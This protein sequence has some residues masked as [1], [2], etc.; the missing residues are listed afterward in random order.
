MGANDGSEVE[1][2]RGRKGRPSTEAVLDSTQRRSGVKVEEQAVGEGEAGERRKSTRGSGA[3]EG[4]GLECTG[5]ASDIE[6][7]SRRRSKSTGQGEADAV[8]EDVR[9]SKAERKGRTS[10]S[11]EGHVLESKVE[12]KE[13]KDAKEATE[14]KESKETKEV[15]ETKEAKETKEDS[16]IAKRKSENGDVQMEKCEGSDDTVPAQKDMEDVKEEDKVEDEDKEVKTKEEREDKGEEKQ[17]QKGKRGKKKEEKELR[18][19]RE[20]NGSEAFEVAK[21]VAE[22]DKGWAIDVVG[23]GFGKASN[24]P[25]KESMEEM[26]TEKRDTLENS[27][28][29]E[30]MKEADTGCDNS[31]DKNSGE[32]ESEETVQDCEDVNDEG[33]ND[34]AEQTVSK[35]EG[36]EK[37]SVSKDKDKDKDKEHACE[38]KEVKEKK[39]SSKGSSELAALQQDVS[40]SDMLMSSMVDTGKRRCTPATYFTYDDTGNQT[41][42]KDLPKGSHLPNKSP[43]K[44][45]GHRGKTRE[46][47]GLGVEPTRAGRRAALEAF[48]EPPRRERQQPER[49]D[50]MQA[51]RV[52]KAK[53]TPPS[54]A[55]AAGSTRRTMNGRRDSEGGDDD[56]STANGNTGHDDKEGK[57]GA[58]RADSHA[59]GNE[60]GLIGRGKDGKKGTPQKEEGDDALLDDNANQTRAVR[61]TRKRGAK[62]EEEVIE[63]EIDEENGGL[64][65]K[66]GRAIKK[67]KAA[68]DEVE[69]EEA[70]NTGSTAGGEEGEEEDESISTRRIVIHG[71]HKEDHAQHVSKDSELDSSR[72]RKQTAD[73]D[74]EGDEV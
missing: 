4:G 67:D 52:K 23:K 32:H 70:L 30:E 63:A 47:T 29:N 46:L 22:N 59:D 73:E 48:E 66:K 7:G 12:V 18:S 20:A 34:D 35:D 2:K 39:R 24:E 43:D 61:S 28:M 27:D 72:K 5:V 45:E 8:K 49:Y 69:V 33:A 40:K 60:N 41:T 14:P 74:G 64:A 15:K 51:P 38:K 62:H 57:A 25:V 26:D 50:A 17:N 44:F 54:V 71:K 16:K 19:P 1:A 55:K 65:K 42:S 56:S 13:V 10:K 31:A 36:K 21:M 11:I 3:G 6:T 58:T 68:E 9:E 53:Q 37:E